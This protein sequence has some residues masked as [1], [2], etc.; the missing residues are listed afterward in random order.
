MD[1]ENR[2]KLKEALENIVYDAEAVLQ[3]PQENHHRLETIV[4]VAQKQLKA[5]KEEEERLKHA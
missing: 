4:A 1:K 5:L 2:F 3:N